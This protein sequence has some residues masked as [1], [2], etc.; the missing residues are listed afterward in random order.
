GRTGTAVVQV[1]LLAESTRRTGFDSRVRTGGSRAR[2]APVVRL[3]GSPSRI[4][5]DGGGPRRTTVLAD[6]LHAA[7]EPLRTLRRRVRATRTL[8]DA[9]ESGGRIKCPRPPVAAADAVP[10]DADGTGLSRFRI[11]GGG[12][13]L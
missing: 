8:A 13:A 4:V 5:P 7:G 11:A 2:G 10:R 3:S 9:G 12:R 6:A 1:F